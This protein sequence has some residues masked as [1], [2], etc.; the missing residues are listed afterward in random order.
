MTAFSTIEDLA[1]VTIQDYKL[2]KLYR[3]NPTDWE[4]FIAGYVVRG[5][6][7]FGNSRIDLSYDLNTL[8]FNADLTND[9]IV[10]LVNLFVQMWLERVQFNL[11]RLGATMTPSDAK[12]TSI[13]SMIKEQQEL[14]DRT[15]EK[16][17]Q[18]MTEYGRNSVDWGNWGNGIF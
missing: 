7:L 12:R 13:Y 18:L 5:S 15:R 17:S 14:I 16:N 4:T 3:D 10:I 1:L 2:D 8:S 11:S 6:L 9:E